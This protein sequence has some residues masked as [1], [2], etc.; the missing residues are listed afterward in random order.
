MAARIGKLIL[1]TTLLAASGGGGYYAV[2]K[3][4]DSKIPPQFVL[5][6]PNDGRFL[7]AFANHVTDDRHLDCMESAIGQ[8][9]NLSLRFISLREIVKSPETS[10]PLEEAKLMKDRSG[11]LYLRIKIESEDLK[12]HSLH[13]YPKSLKIFTEELKKF[14]GPI[15]IEPYYE[16]NA[17]HIAP[18]AKDRIL[19]ILINSLVKAPNVTWVWNPSLGQ[20]ATYLNANW[21]SLNCTQRFENGK[22]Q[23]FEEIFTPQFNSIDPGQ[24]IM[25][26]VASVAPFAERDAFVIKAAEK[27]MAEKRIKGITFFNAP[28]IEGNNVYSVALPR[29]T[30]EHLKIRMAKN[31]ELLVSDIFGST[32]KGALPE[33]DKKQ[34]DSVTEKFYTHFELK[35]RKRLEENIAEIKQKIK[36]TK[37]GDREM[38]LRQSLAQAYLELASIEK[39]EGKIIP[40]LEKAHAIL[41]EPLDDMTRLKA[42][43]KK[44]KR[45]PIVRKYFDLK[46]QLVELYSSLNDLAKAKETLQETLADLENERIQVEQQIDEYSEKGIQNRAYLELGLIYEMMGNNSQAK[47]ISAQLYS[48]TK[49]CY[50]KAGNW[51]SDEQAR[52]RIVLFWKGEN[53]S[54]LRFVAARAKSGLF[55]VGLRQNEKPEKDAL[56][57]LIKILEWKESGR[58][59][60]FMNIT[61]ETFVH[62]M[63][64]YLIENASSARERFN[65]ELPWR[66]INKYADLKKALGLEDVELDS[67]SLDKWGIILDGLAGA[68]IPNE[69]VTSDLAILRESLK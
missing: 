61:F 45:F 32:K 3:A 24:A 2:K 27:A 7:G 62:I 16:A 41:K 21:T 63:R 10:F 33:P 46:L 59:D 69:Q 8:K 20:P 29:T 12:P 39:E 34:C 44:P 4:L 54:K 23:N 31:N 35:K 52:N 42:T 11:S 22:W 13:N 28:L 6:L 53:R 5:P 66:K 55:R 25:L 48:K 9:I 14:H 40:L 49:D 65:K 30:L 36:E 60:G 51:A 19:N 26:F 56:A 37:G 38:P 17:T 43:H 47:E 18:Q 1:T 64:Y 58:E 57:G 50:G 68:E 15:I 67:M